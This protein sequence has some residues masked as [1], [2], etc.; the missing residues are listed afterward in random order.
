MNLKDNITDADRLRK[1]LAEITQAHRQSREQAHDLT[2]R[3]ET[4]ETSK[5]A[6]EAQLAGTHQNAQN[7]RV[8]A[9]QLHRK[10]A[11]G[12]SRTADLRIQLEDQ[13]ATNRELME[14]NT[15]LENEIKMANINYEAARNELD[16]FKKAL[17]D[18]RSEATQTSGRVRQRYF[19]PN[20]A[21][22]SN[23]RTGTDSLHNR[24]QPLPSKA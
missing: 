15:R 20:S 19:K 16:A 7:L 1:E 13:Q 17:R 4:T 11:D 21:D 23:H 12:E 10:V 5:N 14:T 9:E 22:N 2:R 24:P 18:I 8:E 6:L 3:L